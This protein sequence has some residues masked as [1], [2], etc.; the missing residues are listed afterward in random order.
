MNKYTL[1]SFVDRIVSLFIRRRW[2][3]RPPRICVYAL[4]DWIMSERANWRKS[5]TWQRERKLFGEPGTQYHWNSSFEPFTITTNHVDH[6]RW[7]FYF[8]S[9][10]WHSVDGI[11]KYQCIRMRKFNFQNENNGISETKNRRRLETQTKQQLR[12]LWMVCWAN[13]ILC[14][15]Y[16]LCCSLSISLIHTK[17]SIWA[18]GSFARSFGDRR[19]CCCS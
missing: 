15:M 10:A 9:V 1:A 2:R 6:I 14:S 11:H 16:P 3:R 13:A 4:C 7:F 5:Q 17:H 12:L 19:N 8:L 18:S